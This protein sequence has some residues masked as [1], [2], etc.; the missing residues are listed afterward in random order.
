MELSPVLHSLR[1][2]KD[3]IHCTIHHFRLG[4]YSGAH[5]TNLFYYP[6]FKPI[7]FLSNFN[8]EIEALPQGIGL[9]EEGCEGGGRGRNFSKMALI[10]L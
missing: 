7:L 3:H 2:R 9:R 6:Q 10:D 1:T 5:P 8:I 4:T